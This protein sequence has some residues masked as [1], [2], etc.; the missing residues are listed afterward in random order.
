[1]LEAGVTTTSGRA[2]RAHDLRHYV[3][4]WVMRPDGTFPLVGAAGLVS[5]S[6]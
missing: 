5:W 1:M 4:G 2:P 3:D 6:A